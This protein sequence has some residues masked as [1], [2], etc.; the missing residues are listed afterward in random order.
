MVATGCSSAVKTDLSSIQTK[1]VPTSE[2][3]KDTETDLPSDEQI[4]KWQEESFRPVIEKWLK[5]ERL[6]QHVELERNDEFVSVSERGAR[7]ELLDVNGDGIKELAMQTGCAT[8]G[9][10]VF[11]VFQKS[12]DGYRQI[13]SA[14]MVQR[15]KLK[16]TKSNA[17]FDIETS[18]HGSST[19]GDI[20]IYKYDG[21]EYK[22][23]ECAAYEY[24]S[25]GKLDRDGKAII[26]ER[27]VITPKTC[28]T[29]SE[30]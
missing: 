2:S 19:T 25:T 4:A 28:D 24:R 21:K 22:I 9:N 16:K 15:F 10:C 26:D 12:S 5:G 6:P 18:S 27:P 7:V 11:F 29:G 8:V 1:T 17:Y 30:S 13:I 14:D 3:L 23:A 20:S